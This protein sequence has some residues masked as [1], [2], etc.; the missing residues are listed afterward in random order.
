MAYQPLGK[1]SLHCLLAMFVDFRVT[2]FICKL[3]IDV[4]TLYQFFF[5]FPVVRERFALFY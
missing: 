1:T 4:W 3:L 5:V 2:L